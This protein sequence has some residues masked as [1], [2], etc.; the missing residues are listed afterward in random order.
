MII[1]HGIGSQLSPRAA[2]GPRPYPQARELMTAVVP[3]RILSIGDC[4][5][6]QGARAQILRQEVYEVTSISLRTLQSRSMRAT[7]K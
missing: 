7:L 4:E 2:A 6:L 3:I 1:R 5:P